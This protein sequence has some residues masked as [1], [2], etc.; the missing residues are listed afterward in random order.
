MAI[1]SYNLQIVGD[2]DIDA[3]LANIERRFVQH[4][5][6]V[7]RALAMGGGTIRHRNTNQ[8]PQ[9]AANAGARAAIS[10]QRK[11]D[12]EQVASIRKAASAARAEQMLA[13]RQELTAHRL[14]LRH[15]EEQK[16]AEISGIRAAVRERAREEKQSRQSFR[17]SI[18]TGV[19]NAGSTLAAV[20]KG[21]AAMI[22]VGG[23]VL[24]ASAVSEQLKLDEQIRR[25]SIA[26]RDVGTTGL[27]PETVR[28]QVMGIAMSRGIA[29]EAVMA[30]AQQFQTITG[31]GDIGLKMADTFATFGQATGGDPAEIAAAAASLFSNL[32]IEDI[33]ALT[34]ALAKL[35]F[36]GKKGS[37]EFK[38]M[39]AMLPRIT[40][41][42]AGRG[43][44][45]GGGGVAKMGAALQVIQKG[46]GSAEISANAFDSMLR[47][48]VARA[49]DIQKG[50]AFSTGKKVNVFEGGDPTGKF[51]GDFDRLIADVLLA[52]GG[53]DIEL[54]KIFGD[55]GKKGLNLFA[56]AFK[57]AG[58][59]QAGHAAVLK[60]FDEFANVQGNYSEIQRDAADV[61]Q[62]TS[63]QLE[64]ALM[65]LKGAFSDE[66]LPVVKQFVP[67]LKNLAPAA[68]TA[69]GM[70]VSL[71]KSLADNPVLGLG[72]ILAAGITAE[73]AKAQLASIIQGGVVTPL[74]AVGIA[75]G[76][77]G[78]ALLS[79]AAFLDAKANEG[80]AAAKQAAARGDEIRKQAQAEIDATGTL[81]PETRAKLQALEQTERKTLTAADETF[82]EST[83]SAYGRN[84]LDFFGNDKAEEE[85]KRVNALRGAATSREFQEGATETRRLLDVD[86]M[87]L[88]PAE[89]NAQEVGAEIG[90]AAVAQ[91]SKAPLNRGNSPSPV[92]NK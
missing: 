50:T 3:A 20:G 11:V 14:K 22:G 54:Q 2:R 85:N 45:G 56:G 55:E 80:K 17:R 23:S 41:A 31:R 49:D 15:T 35:T 44:G 21:G 65:E 70:F 66:L 1:L 53:N 60:L 13:Q 86:K 58:G 33:N 48:M 57:D 12:R 74:G 63:I 78:A 67:E 88:G 43:I 7:N 26:G 52:S 6:R 92:V 71:G 24:A 59:G 83:L 10:A 68:R 25:F 91:I 76:L 8:S 28:R 32:K 29:P 38:D 37:F 89:F 87:K 75:A 47:Q 82:K 46:T 19:T 72:A 4:N 36:Q 61:Q 27:D 42:M 39:A 18:G 90:K 30:G 64:L 5:L 77:A 40:G 81:T 16:R 79:F 69:A 34:D 62:A 9:Q 84:A 51:R 73:I